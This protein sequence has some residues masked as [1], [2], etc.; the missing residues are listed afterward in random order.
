[1][2][3]LYFP[4]IERNSYFVKKI[5]AVSCKCIRFIHQAFTVLDKYIEQNVLDQFT[6]SNKKA[7]QLQANHPLAKIYSDEV[8]TGRR[9][10]GQGLGLGPGVS[11]SVGKGQDWWQGLP[12]EKV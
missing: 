8:R 10:R 5:I 9:H 12:S 4:G 11:M 2:F 7:F 6:C 1:M 3:V